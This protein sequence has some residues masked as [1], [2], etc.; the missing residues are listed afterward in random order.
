MVLV[1]DLA[2][3]LGTPND[4]FTEWTFTIRDD[5]KWE[6]GK[7]VTPE[8]VAFGIK[9]SLDSETFPGGPGTEYSTSY[10][11]G[12]D[13]YK[14]PYTDK[15]KEYD[16]V[17][18]DGQ[19]VT[20][21]MS[22]PFPDMDYWGSFMAMGAIPTGNVSQPPDYGQKPLSNGP[23]KVESFQPTVELTLVRN[24]QW[25][26]ATDA[27]RTQYPDK[28]V[29]KFNADQNKVDQIFLNDSSD[30]QAA[31]STGTGAANYSRISNALGDRLV[32]QSSQCTSFP[33]PVYDKTSLNVRKA[34]AY[35]LQL[36]GHLARLR[37][38]AGRHARPGELDHA[39]GHGR[40]A[41][42]TSPTASSSPSSPR[43]PR[44]SSR[45]TATSRASTS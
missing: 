39:P 7:P 30:A 12:A 8:E 32:Q 6:D 42:T 3:S 10:F 13:D 40:Q 29:F 17:T 24:D 35:G 23:Y 9:R 38:G 18:V 44:S 2:T 4:D 36:R 14:G 11:A 31:V 33:Y 15:N 25:D 5:V 27:A 41:R 43:R 22:K 20:I 37:R 19:D 28:Y 21:K 34:I 45:R 16:G 26:P 1:P